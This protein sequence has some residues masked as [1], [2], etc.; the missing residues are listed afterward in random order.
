MENNTFSVFIWD[1]SSLSDA[2]RSVLE[3]ACGEILPEKG[4]V[5]IAG[6][7]PGKEEKVLSRS[8]PKTTSSAGL[9]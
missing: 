4:P 8:R 3:S 7:F 6:V 5:I 9:L 1:A 2:V